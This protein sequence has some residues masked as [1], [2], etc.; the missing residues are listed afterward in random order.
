MR[1]M[2]YYRRLSFIKPTSIKELVI[3]LG[4]EEYPGEFKQ[5]ETHAQP[6]D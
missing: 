6:C 3:P 5:V 2:D 4:D 1:H